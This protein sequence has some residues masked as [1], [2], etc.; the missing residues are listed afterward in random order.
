M[1][2][3]PPLPENFPKPTGLRTRAAGTVAVVSSQDGDPSLPA[4]QAFVVRFRAVSDSSA[5]AVVGKIEHV[6]S[7]RGIRFGS[8]GDMLDFIRRILAERADGTEDR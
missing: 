4:D 3:A 5:D 7:G 2:V 6:R 8:Y 1:R